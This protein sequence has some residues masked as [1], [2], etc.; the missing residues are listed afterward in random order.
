M[1]STMS[2]Y[3]EPYRVWYLEEGEPQDELETVDGDLLDLT[4]GN[5]ICLLKEETRGR[6]L[7]EG[8][9]RWNGHALPSHLSNMY[10]IDAD[11]ATGHLEALEEE[12]ICYAK[13][14]PGSYSPGMGW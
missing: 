2:S 10:G 7:V 3:N 8:E 14:W 12:G 4:A 11:E 5:P 9:L 1:K 6:D 13:E